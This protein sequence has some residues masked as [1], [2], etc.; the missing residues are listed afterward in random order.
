MAGNDMSETTMQLGR[1]GV[2]A[3]RSAWSPELAAT[4]ERLGYGT[5]W[6]GN[7]HGDLQKVEELL[8][9]TMTLRVATG[10]VNIWPYS[11]ESVAA[12]YHRIDR[13]YPG[14]FL[15]GVGVGHPEMVGADYSNP[16][17]ALEH[18]LDVLDET[19]VPAGR[20]A[21]A[22]LG[23]RVLRLSAQRS[24]G[25]HPYLTTPEH[26]RR[27][28]EILGQEALLAPEQKV[29]LTGD[30]DHARAIGREGLAP[31]LGMINYVNNLHSLGFTDSD[32]LSPGS[33]RLIDELFAH[34]EVDEVVAALT[35][36][37]EAGADHVAVQVVGVD[38]LV[39][40]LTAIA[41]RLVE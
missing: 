27:A 11:A 5:A 18:Y 36:H 23:R 4:V 37:V 2:W 3:R 12:A 7:P 15:L 33:D 34:G 10:I 29:I 20:R 14:R 28:R 17:Q 35:A 38:D 30:R 19:G 21:L 13:V 40:H 26:T 39:P 22:A 16:Y 1:F 41:D 8:A 6:I 31:Y 9:A 25:A 24:A 32:L